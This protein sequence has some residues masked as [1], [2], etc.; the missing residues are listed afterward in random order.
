MAHQ[1]LRGMAVEDV[2]PKAADTETTATADAE[3]PTTASAADE[4]K[5]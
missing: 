1:L 4:A 2:T 3:T 5:R